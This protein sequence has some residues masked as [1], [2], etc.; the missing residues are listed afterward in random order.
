MV[1]KATLVQ[2]MLGH[3]TTKETW[4]YLTGLYKKVGIAYGKNASDKTCMQGTAMAKIYY[5]YRRG[6]CTEIFATEITRRHHEKVC[7]C[8]DHQQ[9][10]FPC[11]HQ[12]G[13]SW[14]KESHCKKHEKHCK[15]RPRE[16]DAIAAPVVPAMVDVPPIVIQPPRPAIPRQQPDTPA[17]PHPPPSADQA[18]TAEEE[19]DDVNANLDAH[20]LVMPPQVVE[21]YGKRSKH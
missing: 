2:Y 6:G 5:A 15:K 14:S 11:K 4:E 1:P 16:Q 12:C 21:R 20:R 9:G 3:T 10:N 7:T 18:P 19:E 17:P 13:L 8:N